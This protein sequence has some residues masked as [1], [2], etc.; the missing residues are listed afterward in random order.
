[1]STREFSWQWLRTM[2]AL[3]G[4]VV[5]RT[6]VKRVLG[7]DAETGVAPI[8]PIVLACPGRR[9]INATNDALVDERRC[10]SAMRRF[11]EHA[12]AY[13]GTAS[14][15]LVRAASSL[16]PAAVDER[17]SD[18]RPWNALSCHAPDE[19]APMTAPLGASR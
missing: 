17:P 16:A 13:R 19:I 7:R 11:A 3:A 2:A 9:P 4:L 8:S 5:P 15:R 18:R 1:S 10:D 14:R 12:S 6:S